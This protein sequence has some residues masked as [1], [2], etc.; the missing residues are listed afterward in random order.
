MEGFSSEVGNQVDIDR[1]V[2]RWMAVVGKTMQPASAG[3]WVRRNES[4]P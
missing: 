1:L 4:A 3:V 2:H